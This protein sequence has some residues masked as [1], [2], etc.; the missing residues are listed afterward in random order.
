MIDAV[1]MCLR[2]GSYAK[3]PVYLAQGTDRE[4]NRKMLSFWVMGASGE[5]SN[6]WRE[7]ISELAGRG[8]WQVDIFISDDL[9]GI[10]E[11]TKSV[12]PGS[13]HQ[14]YVVHALRNVASKGR[15]TDRA[16]VLAGLK[17][18]YRASY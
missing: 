14:L 7:I 5:S 18:V 6:A 3:E 13:D 2:R 10:E 12:F 1:F 11:A 15:R 16:V 17:S 8:V 9:P 4:K